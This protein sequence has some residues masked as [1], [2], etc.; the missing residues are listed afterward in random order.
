MGFWV[1]SIVKACNLSC[2]YRVQVNNEDLV[3]SI[4]AAKQEKE[5]DLIIDSQIKHL[6]QVNEILSTHV[7]F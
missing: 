6:F 5:I 7:D 1:P 2:Y 4:E 3:L